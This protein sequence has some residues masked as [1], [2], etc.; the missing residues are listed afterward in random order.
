M[1]K[2]HSFAAALLSGAMVLSA[3][4]PSLAADAQA[5]PGVK[6]DAEVAA[7]LGIL[8]G[9]GNG[10]TAAYLAKTTTRLQAAILFLRLKGL[11]QTA[12]SFTGTDNFSDASS[13]SD[14]NKAIL[15]YL[16]ANPS[17]GW[18]GTGSGKFDPSASITDQQY[19]KVLLEAL[20]YKQDSDF[21]YD[22]VIAFAKDHG[23]SQIAGTGGLRN[24]HIATA[25]VEALGLKVKG[26]GKTL[27][28]MLADQKVVDKAK[29]VLVQAARI[30]VAQTPEL[31]SFLVDAAGKTL[32]YYA[33][34]MPDMS[35]CK[36]QCAVNWPI[37]YAENIQ[38]SSELNA[39]DF[40]T[41]VRED[42]KKQTTYK[43]MPLYYFAK[44]EKAGDVKGQGVNNVWY[45]VPHSA[46]I[47][48]KDDKLGPYLADSR[49]M[50]LYLY[51][52]DTTNKSVCYGNCEVAWPVFY[53]E[54]ITSGGDLKAEDFGVIVRDDGTKQSTYKGWPLYYYVKDEKPGDVKGQDVGKVWYVIDPTPSKQTE[55]AK[56]AAKAY[57][58]DIK[59]FKF[60]QPEIT[61]EAG[62]SITFTNRDQFKHNVVSD[63]MN[64]DKPLFE[65]PLLGEG[66]SA[67]LTFDKPGVYTY[68]CAPH[69]ASMKGT[70]IVK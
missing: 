62:S 29:A 52:K 13:V 16:K 2:R 32:Y 36:D 30:N 18:A 43:G 11:E 68:Y 24:S 44:D 31:G 26:G 42:G 46:V 12:L 67:T 1:T 19:Y 27:A 40:K 54:H 15:A 60:A 58:M 63:E 65:T 53:S 48:A 69:K 3:A 49:G 39:A 70:I 47:V 33:K 50:A 45:V 56:P 28:D 7:D 35:M 59:S 22:N 57:A 41:I 66:E 10:V 9:D 55:A 38:V 61:I 64:G 17:L 14:S 5:S 6:T 25:T 51:T 23:L 34:D 20:G 8:Q 21:T 37:Y 4:A